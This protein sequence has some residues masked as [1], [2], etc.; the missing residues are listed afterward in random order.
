MQKLRVDMSANLRRL[1]LEHRYTQD[2]LVAKLHLLEVPV[3][4]A[5]YSRYE[6][7]ELN[8]PVRTL[9]ALHTLYRCSYDAFFDGLQ[10][11]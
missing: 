4:R 11:S 5:V 3:T 9:V 7:G 10:L 8:I 2:Q 1:R 6:T